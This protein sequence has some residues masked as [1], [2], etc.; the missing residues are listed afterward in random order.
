MRHRAAASILVAAAALSVSG[1]STAE[2]YVASINPFQRRDAVEGERR[3]ALSVDAQ[4]QQVTF[5]RAAV[6]PQPIRAGD[7]LNVGGTPSG[8]NPH[9]DAPVSAGWSRDGS[10]TR[11]LSPPISVGGRLIVADNASLRA[12]AVADGAPVWSV[13]LDPSGSEPDAV[14]P[15]VASDGGRIFATTGLQ[16]LTAFDAATGT[17]LWSVALPEPVRGI[18]V[19]SSN[20]VY[21]LLGLSSAI[22][23]D[24]SNGSEIWR[25]TGVP[26]A[27]G[28]G[29][30]TAPAV[31]AQTVAFTTGSGELVL[32]DAQRGTQRASIPMTRASGVLGSASV[33]DVASR[34]VIDRG[35]V[36]AGGSQ[37][38]FL[39]VREMN[40]ERLF[41]RA[42]GM[43]HPPVVSGDT[44][45]ILAS[46][47]RVEALDRMSGAIKWLRPLPGD[48]RT[49]YAGPT[50][51][52]GGLFIVSAAGSVLRLE[53]ANGELS[54]A[55]NVPPGSILSAIPTAAG[56]VITTSRGT[57]A[58]FEG[59]RRS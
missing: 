36:Y 39:A 37:G 6:L 10:A 15:G 41:D 40:G 18:P 54:A 2:D 12:V 8:A 59:A 53:A 35:I 29:T 47:G 57:I 24:A 38:R 22:A 16:R 1:C 11:A 19:A 44:V 42:V 20:R 23:I 48:G 51:V 21:L 27:I 49:G 28:L 52:N 13:R 25:H 32:L 14:N 33:S 50:L 55:G 26:G 4:L 46:D 17:T 58:S 43:A 31:S 56:L 7:W 45:F 5:V 3:P 34:P 30:A 9:V